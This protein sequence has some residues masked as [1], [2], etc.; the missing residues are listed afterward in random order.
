MPISINPQMMREIIMDHYNNPLHKNVPKN[1]E[2]YKK[3]RMDSDS[4]IDDI[5]I[6]IKIEDDKI[7]DACFEGVA[8][9]ISTSSTDILCDLIIGKSLKDALY[10]VEQYKN[11][12]VILTLRDYVFESFKEQARDIAFAAIV[13]QT[14]DNKQI[15][16]IVKDGFNIYNPKY[17]N[18]IVDIAKGNLRFAIM[19]AEVITH[20]KDSVSSIP[21]VLESYYKSIVQSVKFDENNELASTLVAISFSL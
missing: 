14:L 16:D 10:I 9:T 2:G 11:V 6:Y 20:S 8:C 1:L 17:L 13:L 7:I 5:T 21:E 4:C 15:A 18:Y 19:T 12:Y 3:I